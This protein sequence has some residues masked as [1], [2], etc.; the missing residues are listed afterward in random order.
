MPKNAVTVIIFA[1]FIASVGASLAVGEN[2]EES[3]F[4]KSLH[5]TGEGMR[6]S[7]EEQGGFMDITKIPYNDL[8][9][10]GCHV[11]TCDAC[12]AKKE[13]DISSFSVDKA[14]DMDTCIVCHSRAGLTFRMGKQ[15][16]NLDVHVKAGM[17]CSS[18]HKGEDVH[19]T[20]KSHSAMRD[21]GAV[22]AECA[23]CHT[24]ATDAH[25]PAVP[26]TD[27]LLF[28]GGVPRQHVERRPPRVSQG[29]QRHVPR[30]SPIRVGRG[31]N[32]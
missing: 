23:N 2:P 21:P 26:D 29:F 27:A 18:C 22:K 5:H 10:K 3:F 24:S 9:C 1:F 30:P 14:R 19:G 31:S 13:G 16:D 12:H 25:A 11:K 15:K 32:G 20:G 28:H 7:Y 8:D 4:S 17:N 6:Y